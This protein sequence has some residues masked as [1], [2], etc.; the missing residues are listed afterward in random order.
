M[1]FNAILSFPWIVESMLDRDKII[2][3]LAVK[4]VAG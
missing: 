4:S 1:S 3:E 2:N